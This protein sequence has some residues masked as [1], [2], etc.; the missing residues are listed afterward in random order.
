MT[1][2]V[3]VFGAHYM[4]DFVKLPGVS[5]NQKDIEHLKYG[6]GSHGAFMK[7]K[8]AETNENYKQLIPYAIVRRGDKILAYQRSKKS[9]EVRLHDK[10][11]IGIG[12]HIN[13]VDNQLELG[14]VTLISMALQ[15]ELEEE[16]NWGEDFDSTV[17]NITEYGV[18]YHESDA[19]SKVHI[20]Y[21]LMIDMPADSKYPIPIEDTIAKSLWLSVEDALK[22]PGLETWSKLILETLVPEKKALQNETS[23]G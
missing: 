21:V 22:L 14:I 2:Q 16:L 20:G 3:F 9:G 7:R 15:R 23:K 12:G 5:K 8:D 18:V 6:C 11:S 19:V 1:E 13:P 4:E 17:H 10:W